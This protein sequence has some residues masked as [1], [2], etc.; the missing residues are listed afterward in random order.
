MT[1][2]FFLEKGKQTV[3][4]KAIVEEVKRVL[5]EESEATPGMPVN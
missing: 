1:T 5:E 3:R 4:T 2:L